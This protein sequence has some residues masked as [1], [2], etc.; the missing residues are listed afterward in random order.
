MIG[1]LVVEILLR[2]IF[3]AA[4]GLTLVTLVALLNG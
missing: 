2:S 4:A 1:H 3:V